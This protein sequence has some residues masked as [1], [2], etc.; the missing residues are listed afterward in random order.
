MLGKLKDKVQNVKKTIK[1]K[2]DS[3]NLRHLNENIFPYSC[4]VADDIILTKNGEVMQ[5]IE[6]LLDDFK[7]NQEGGL[8]DK[9]RQA[10]ANNT[11]DLRTAFWI[12]TIKRKKAKSKSKHSVISHP[13]LKTLYEVGQAKEAELNNY[14]T[15]VYITIIKQGVS[16]KLKPSYIKNYL[17]STFLDYKHN[18][19]I[20]DI[21]K[22]K[23]E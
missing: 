10:I 11:N 6:I 23:D 8:R 9:I 3:F 5:I 18:K 19:H 13:L 4:L 20:D 14:S 21:I 17:S 7:M 1:E 2:Q 15:C 22:E 16:F 12:Q